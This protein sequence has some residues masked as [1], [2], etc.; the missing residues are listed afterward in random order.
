[1]PRRK[2]HPCAPMHSEADQRAP[3]A[4]NGEEREDANQVCGKAKD[5]VG[6]FCGGTC[7]ERARWRVSDRGG[8]WGSRGVGRGPPRLRDARAPDATAFGARPKRTFFM[9]WRRER[10][11]TAVRGMGRIWVL[12]W[13]T[14]RTSRSS[15]GANPVVVAIARAR[16]R[17]LI[18]LAGDANLEARARCAQ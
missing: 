7:R 6:L 16:S 14:T 11:L 12:P 13:S 4:P 10:V 3:S 2:D 9:L 5:A 1:M 15:M 8:R 17:V 18:V